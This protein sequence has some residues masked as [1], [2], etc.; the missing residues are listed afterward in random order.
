MINTSLEAVLEV[1]ADMGLTQNKIK[2][3]VTTYSYTTRLFDEA[4]LYCAKDRDYWAL[5]EQ[6][7]K[8]IIKEQ[9]KIWNYKTEQIDLWEKNK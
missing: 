4:N 7:G 5:R 1:V 8:E 6:L 3:L 2:T 9:L